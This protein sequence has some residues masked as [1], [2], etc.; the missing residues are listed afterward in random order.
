KGTP[1][2]FITLAAGQK[3]WANRF[4]NLTAIRIRRVHGLSTEEQEQRFEH[5]L[6]ATLKPEE[7]G[8]RFE[9]VREQALKAAEQSQDFG[10]L[11]LGFSIFLVVAALLLMA[12]LFQ[13][14]LEQRASEVGTLLALGFPVKQV[15]RLLLMEGATLALLG[16]I[17]GTV[18]GLGYAKAMLWGLATVWRSAVGSFA[19]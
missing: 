13:F 12:L 17:I 15:R 11:F 3:M 8:L 14:G 6:L 5:K 1:K 7:I 2:A 18:G 10:E 16:G 9:P 19:L 4:G